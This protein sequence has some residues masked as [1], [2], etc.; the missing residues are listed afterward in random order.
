MSHVTQFKTTSLIRTL[1]YCNSFHKTAVLFLQE[2]KPEQSMNK[3]STE[4]A[5]QIKPYTHK[6]RIYTKIYIIAIL[7]V[8]WLIKFWGFLAIDL[9]AYNTVVSCIVSWPGLQQSIICMWPHPDTDDSSSKEPDTR[10][11]KQIVEISP[12]KPFIIL[13]RNINCNM[14]FSTSK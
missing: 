5:G 13:I 11:L 2:I 8:E 14:H 9:L 6:C 1:Q 7:I 3:Q 4:N 10:Q 12:H